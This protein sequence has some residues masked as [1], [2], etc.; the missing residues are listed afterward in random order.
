M[1]H[2]MVR[3]AFFCQGEN[4]VVVDLLSVES[5]LNVHALFKELQ[6]AV[7]DCGNALWYDFGVFQRKR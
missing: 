5:S 7:S 6:C 1:H 4:V 3:N 2:L